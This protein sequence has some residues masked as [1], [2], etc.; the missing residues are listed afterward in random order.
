MIKKQVVYTDQRFRIIL[1]AIF[2]ILFV[3]N[4][5]T[6]LAGVIYAA[7]AVLLQG[8][9]IVA[10]LRKHRAQIILIK[11]WAAMIALS[12]VAGFVELFAKILG[13]AL[14]SNV[15]LNEGFQ[16]FDVLYAGAAVAVGYYFFTEISNKL[17]V[18]ELENIGEQAITAG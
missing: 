11:V 2:W 16:I 4:V 14:K 5:Y 6:L 12:G 17:K 9:I 8:S 7:F 15:A 10:M 18:V 13:N 1:V 3:L